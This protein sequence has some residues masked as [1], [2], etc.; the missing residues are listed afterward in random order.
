MEKLLLSLLLAATL[1]CQSGN[2]QQQEAANLE[3]FD[4][5]AWQQYGEEI[6]PEG[7]VAASALLEYA[8][9]RDSLLVKVRGEAIGSCPVKG[10]WMKVRLEDGQEL[11]VTFKDYGFFV[12][13]DL[14][15]EAVI[16]EGYLNRTVTDVETLQ[17][18]ARDEGA[19]D[20][21]VQ[22]IQAPEEAFTFE[23]A[24]VLLKLKGS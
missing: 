2:E 24:G 8:E 20:E 9:G 23:A 22:A 3:N 5:E 19:T 21:E 16:F 17:H 6:N 18:Y 13:K 10:C 12:P 11:R 7:A 4:Q 15:G 1:A 14:D